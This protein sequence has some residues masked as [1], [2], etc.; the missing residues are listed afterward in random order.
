MV[1][2]MTAN[3]ALQLR[4]TVK[5]LAEMF[6]L[7]PERIRQL[8]KLGVFEQDDEGALNVHQCLIGYERASCDPA[9][10]SLSARISE[11]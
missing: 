7:S 2:L 6:D 10:A 1:K 8:I 3:E 9:H 4:V 11:S 5:A